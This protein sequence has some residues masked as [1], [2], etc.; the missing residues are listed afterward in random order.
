M[1]ISVTLYSPYGLEKMLT[2]I[3]FILVLASLSF[4]EALKVDRLMAYAQFKLTK[5]F[6]YFLSFATV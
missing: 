6:F 1:K 4:T 5:C 2:K 3:D